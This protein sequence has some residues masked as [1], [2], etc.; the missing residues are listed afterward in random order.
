MEDVT[1]KYNL[2]PIKG[3]TLKKQDL[4]IS[5]KNESVRKFQMTFSPNVSIS[6]S[7]AAKSKPWQSMATFSA[8]RALE[9]KLINKDAENAELRDRLRE[10]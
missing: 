6:E 9:D 10:V 1:N 7:V 5:M 2:S 3:D 4:E 8:I